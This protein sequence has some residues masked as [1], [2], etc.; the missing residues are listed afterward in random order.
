[1]RARARARPAREGACDVGAPLQADLEGIQRMSTNTV[2]S[3]FPEW[4][5]PEVARRVPRGPRATTAGPQEVSAEFRAMSG[6]WVSWADKLR[7]AIFPRI[8]TFPAPLGVSDSPGALG[9][10]FE[11][12]SRTCSQPSSNFGYGPTAAEDS[13][14]GEAKQ[15]R[16]RIW[17]LT[18]TLCGG[19]HRKRRGRSGS[20]VCCTVFPTPS[21]ARSWSDG[22]CRALLPA[23]PTGRS[24][25]GQVSARWPAAVAS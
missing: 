16:V 18:S 20:G 5:L 17:A 6:I 9:E 11:P 12:P 13:V 4:V 25:H 2:G 19:Q 22:H 21:L 15:Y 23:A 8:G 14:E 7:R 10:H 3:A 24:D 1:M